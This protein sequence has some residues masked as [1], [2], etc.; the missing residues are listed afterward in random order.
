MLLVGQWF[1]AREARGPRKLHVSLS[2]WNIPP[3]DTFFSTG[4]AVQRD[5]KRLQLA[6]AASDVASGALLERMAL[7]AF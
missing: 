7:A 6:S 1:G 3:L 2:R 5:W 4:P